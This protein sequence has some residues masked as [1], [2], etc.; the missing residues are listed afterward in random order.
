MTEARNKALDREVLR[1]WA[2]GRDIHPAL[3]PGVRTAALAVLDQLAEA[4]GVILALREN[5]PPPKT[6]VPADSVMWLGTPGGRIY[7][8]TNA[9]VTIEYPK[10]DGA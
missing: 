6:V 7:L 3:E 8:P 2:Q 1:E 5:G 4:E 9:V 10:G